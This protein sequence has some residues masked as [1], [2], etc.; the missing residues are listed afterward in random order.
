M[1]SVQSASGAGAVPFLS[2]AVNNPNVNSLSPESLLLYCSSR[3]ETLDKNIQKYFAEQQ[4]NNRKSQELSDVIAVGKWGGAQAGPE[5]LLADPN[6]PQQFADKANALANL[7]ATSSTPDA[8]AAAASEFQSLTGQDINNFVSE[9]GVVR[10][11]T[12]DNIKD[13][14][15]GNDGSPAT[16]KAISETE[17]SSRIDTLKT[18]LD[19]FSKNGELNMIQLQSL[20]SQ[21]QL[22]VQLTTQL[23]QTA[24]ETTKGVVGNIRS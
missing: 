3:L 14:A 8:K 18:K 22:A 10:P 2:G 11:V 21:R 13:W 16:I 23:M 7:Y 1:S 17:A 15:N 9:K 24:H 6:G 12:P 19:A 5:A 4:D 20:V